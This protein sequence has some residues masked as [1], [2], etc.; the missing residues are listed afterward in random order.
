MASLLFAAAFAGLLLWAAASDLATMEIPNR[1][2]IIMAAL[3]PAAALVCG[4]EPLSI[5]FHMGLGAAALAIG[6]GLFSLGVF[7]GGDAK[8]IA[9]AAIWTGP[10]VLL[11]FLLVTAIA[12]GG[13]AALA[14]VTRARFK[15]AD[16]MPSFVNRF[17]GERGVPYAVAI[18]AGGLAIVA[19]L[20]IVAS[21]A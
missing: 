8:V 12:G 10:A 2:S 21:A 20:P 16:G 3:Y 6:W 19:R 18:A 1:I 13:L 9:A 11:P 15:P 7:G 14:L 4:M 17:L 5:L